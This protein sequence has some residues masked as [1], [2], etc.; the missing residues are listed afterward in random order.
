MYCRRHLTHI[1]EA[2]LKTGSAT[3]TITQFEYVFL[4]GLGLEALQKPTPAETW[5]LVLQRSQGLDASMLQKIKQRAAEAGRHLVCEDVVFLMHACRQ[6]FREEAS[7]RN[8]FNS[9]NYH[10]AS[11]MMDIATGSVVHTHKNFDVLSSDDPQ[12]P[13]ALIHCSAQFL[14]KFA[15]VVAAGSELEFFQS[16][17]AS[18]E[19]CFE[20]KISN[21]LAFECSGSR[22]GDLW[23]GIHYPV[24][25]SRMGC[26]ENVFYSILQTWLEIQARKFAAAASPAP[27]DFGSEQWKGVVGPATISRGDF[28]QRC[29]TPAEA[30]LFLAELSTRIPQLRDPG[31]AKDI[32]EA[33]SEFLQ[34]YT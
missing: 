20:A 1:S 3:G 4:C 31:N 34:D 24:W 26:R 22:A 15:E 32:E 9:R 18:T 25:D 6:L 12:Q 33:I 28:I 13:G 21:A 2:E 27:I 8:D 29:L 5:S 17:F 14:A 16:G 23:C 7:R 10:P 11:I 19:P 30:H